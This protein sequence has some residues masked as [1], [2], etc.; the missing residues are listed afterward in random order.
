MSEQLAL[1]IDLGGTKIHAGVVSSTGSILG[2]GRHLTE[3]SK[4]A[5][6][7]VGNMVRAAQA[8][9]EDAGVKT[10]DLTGV[11]VGSPAPLDIKR[12]VIINPGNLPSLHGCPVVARLS[13]ALDRLVFLNN[14]ANCFGLAEARFGA[15]AAVSVCCGLTMGTGLGGFLVIGGELF[16]GP[17]GAAAEVWCSP[18][19]GDQVEERVSGRAVTRSYKKLTERVVGAAEIASLARSGDEDAVEAW[20]EFGA[21]LA[22]PV[23]WMCNVVD[24]DVVVLGGSMVRAWDLFEETMLQEARKYV[25]AVTREAVRIVPGALGDA[26]G[27][28][29]AA[30][31]VFSQSR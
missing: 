14:D 24:P 4:D 17:R 5:D 16:N 20:R 18:Y 2:E 10:T 26:A 7:V 13:E 29:G 12:G 25:N 21:A 15:A 6:T 8:A 22:A 30:A 23:S 28:L 9:M 1:G 19:Q 27:I 3:A 31:L 11:G